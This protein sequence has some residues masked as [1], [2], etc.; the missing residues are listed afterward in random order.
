MVS[1]A[2]CEPEIEDLAEFLKSCGA[3]IR[4]AGTDTVEIEGVSSLHGT[5][6][7]VI[8]DR[9]EGG[10]FMLAAAATGGELFLRG[11]AAAAYGSLSFRTCACGM[12][13]IGI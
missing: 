13:G 1:G 9:I 4:G 8:N 6:H 11:G 2:A 7:R 5:R 10:T 3:R 12:Q